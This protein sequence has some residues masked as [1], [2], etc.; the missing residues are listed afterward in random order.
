MNYTVGIIGKGYFGKKIYESLKSICDIKFFTGTDMDVSFDIDWV[1][2]ATSNES[3]YDLVREFISNGVNVFVEKPMTLSLIESKELVDYANS[4]GVKLYIDD[5]FL[6]NPVIQLI[7]NYNL[8]KIRFEWKKYGSFNDN[9]FNNLTYHDIY[10]A[11][12]LGYDLS[13]DIHFKTNR[14]NE[15]EFSIGNVEFYYNRLSDVKSKECIGNGFTF[16]FE[17]N[18]DLLRLMFQNVFSKRVDFERN[19][20]LALKTNLILDRLYQHKPKVAV[21]GAGIF[22]VTSALKLDGDL[23]V[24]LFEKNSDIL[25]NASSINQYR[26]HR[27]YH[28]PRSSDTAISSKRG[29]DSFLDEYPCEVSTSNQHY[30]IASFGS[31]VSSDDYESFMDSVGLEY[32]V[33]NSDLINTSNIDKVY[34][35]NEGI[36]DH[37]KLYEMCKSKLNNSNIRVVYNTE[38]TSDI[39]P[40]YD[41]I[42]NATYANLNSISND[43]CEYQFELCEKPVIK[44][45]SEYKGFGMVIMDGPFMCI[46][47]YSDTE[48]HVLGN[49]THAIH[50]TNVGLFPEIPEV[51]SGL[52][53]NGIVWNPFITNWDLMKNTLSKF[54]KNVDEVEHIG[55]MFTVRTVFANRD[56]DDARPSIVKRETDSK[57]LIFSGKISTAVDTANELYTYIMKS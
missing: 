3:H 41:Y 9:I 6:Y 44:L 19:N 16:N 18:L 20:E 1:V 22:G 23:D 32:D 52:L 28:Y 31:K 7:P 12:H 29:T 50:H 15:K 8:D 21:I 46:D 25:Q 55:S 26:L 49:V 13:G 38:Y 37:C 4:V 34:K 54:F 57:Y 43:K 5:V 40:A 14:I 10:I 17:T 51:Y 27:G 24:T 56:F 53:N 30:A 45:P 33:V 11:L 48:Y 36:F 39:E 47:P 42:V 35:V 2:I